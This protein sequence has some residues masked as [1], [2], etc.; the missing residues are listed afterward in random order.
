M[1][2]Y[3]LMHEYKRS[4]VMFCTFVICEE[5]FK[6]IT[7]RKRYCCIQ[8]I[9][10]WVYSV[11]LRI[12]MIKINYISITGCFCVI[13]VLSASYIVIISRRSGRISVCVYVNKMY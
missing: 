7:Q 11:Y 2:W 4:D 5:N 12:C 9:V 13:E 3:C 1:N 10:Q 8:L 6:T